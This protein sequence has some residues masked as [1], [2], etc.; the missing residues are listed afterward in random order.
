MAIQNICI[1][2]QKQNNKPFITTYN[3]FKCKT[4]IVRPFWQCLNVCFLRGIC[5]RR[6]VITR[7]NYHEYL[8]VMVPLAVKVPIVILKYVFNNN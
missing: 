3:I 7:P 6:Y 2:I 8:K 4:G 1:D 5:A